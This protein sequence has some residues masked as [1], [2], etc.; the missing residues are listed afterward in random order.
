MVCLRILK[1][2]PYKKIKSKYLKQLTKALDNP[3]T[4]LRL[5]QEF[6]QKFR[7]YKEGKY[8][9]EDLPELFESLLTSKHLRQLEDILKEI[10]TKKNIIKEDNIVILTLRE[11]INELEKRHSELQ[12]FILKINKD[13][14]NIDENVDMKLQRIGQKLDNKVLKRRRGRPAKIIIDGEEK[15]ENEKEEKN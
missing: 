7:K 5:Y 2:I 9:I 10:D 4:Y 8:E 6:Y 13:M 11:K 3:N 14:K 15:K 1:T 12:E